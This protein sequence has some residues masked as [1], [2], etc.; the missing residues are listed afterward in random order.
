MK[1]YERIHGKQIV[2]AVYSIIFFPGPLWEFF[3]F[4]KKEH[5]Q[6]VLIK[7][8][9]YIFLFIFVYNGTYKITIYFRQSKL[10]DC[11]VYLQCLNFV[12]TF[13]QFQVFSHISILQK[14]LYLKNLSHIKMFNIFIKRNF[15]STKQRAL[16]V[17]RY[18]LS[19]D[20]Q[21]GS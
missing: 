18:G 14:K 7:D 17:L 9:I 13:L 4:L 10:Y 3:L 5:F 16:G 8:N 1:K 2:F 20:K 6:K 15:G 11:W 19:L 21:V 12:G